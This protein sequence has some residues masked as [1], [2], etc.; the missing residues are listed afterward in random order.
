[1]LTKISRRDFIKRT[2]ASG[3]AGGMVLSGVGKAA[4]AEAVSTAEP[5]GTFID[6]TAC[7]GCKGLEVPK[8]VTAC[9][10]K[11]KEKFPVPVEE[12]PEYWPK[13][14]KED[15]SDK[16]GLTTRLTPYNWTFIQK[17]KIEHNSRTFEVNIPRR[18][19]HCANPPCANICPMGAQTVSK[20]GVVHINPEI[21]FGGA[22]CREVCPWGIPAR[23][24]GVGLYM[25]MMPG[26]V[27]GGVMYK[28]D[29]CLDLIRAGQQPACVEE[30]PQDAIHFGNKSEMLALAKTRAA[31]I[32]G[33][34][35]GE[36]ENGGTSTY[37]VSPVPF[38]KI[39]QALMAQKAKQP[40]PDA[41]GFPGMPVNVGNFLD[42]ANGIAAGVLIT[43]VAGLFAAGYKAYKTMKGENT[44]DI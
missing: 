43:P 8:C 9:R 39:D 28:C 30:C 41:P 21:C 34:L 17:T 37:Y 19:M 13:K 10:T 1:M 42:T 29:L 20:E 26:L 35:Y 40:N 11:N 36:K 7:D 25:K 38:A 31:E 4:P 44:D 3:I 12:I 27:G 23:Q 16:K 15:W 5:V 6:L 22:K 24:A 14:K 2:V 18:C 32:N 33:Y